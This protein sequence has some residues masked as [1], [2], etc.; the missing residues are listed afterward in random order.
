[1]SLETGMTGFFLSLFSLL[2]VPSY[3]P[4][5]APSPDWSGDP[6]PSISI[7]P[8]PAPTQLPRHSHPTLDDHV[9]HRCASVTMQLSAPPLPK[10]YRMDNCCRTREHEERIRGNDERGGGGGGDSAVAATRRGR[11]QGGVGVD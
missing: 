11:S 8:S 2:A 1:M 9:L 5:R 6:P 4:Y 10:K 7:L 3:R